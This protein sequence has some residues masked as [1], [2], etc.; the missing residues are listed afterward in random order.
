M[1]V[2]H[3]KIL[4]VVALGLGSGCGDASDPE[5]VSFQAHALACEV[6]GMQA[7]LRVTGLEM[8]VCHLQVD[9]DGT[10][11]GLCGGVPGG[12]E[13]T[14]SLEY[15][16]VLAMRRVLLAKVEL[17]VDLTDETDD[18]VPLDFSQAPVFTDLDDDNDGVSNLVEFCSGRDPLA[19]G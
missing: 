18:V 2:K 10:V 4:T 5:P 16:V 3:L 7:W 15:Y 14:F 12:A 9:A 1:M 11:S 13:R 19:P 6:P 8:R 17:V